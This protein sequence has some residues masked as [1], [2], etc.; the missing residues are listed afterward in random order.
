MTSVKI[1]DCVTAAVCLVHQ[2]HLVSLE[3]QGAQVRPEYRDLPETLADL[4][5][6]PVNPS[7]HHLAVHALLVHPDLLAS[8]VL[9]EC[10]D[11]VD[12]LV[13]KDLLDL[14]DHKE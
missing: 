7:P 4:H 12:L 14:L 11:L 8:L 10:Q 3:D 9:L 6:S 1:P 2:A 13:H 5:S